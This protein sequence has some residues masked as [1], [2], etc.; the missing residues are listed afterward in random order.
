[1][2]ASLLAV[3]LIACVLAVIP[4]LLCSRRVKGA[5]V[6]G[7]SNSLVISASCHVVPLSAVDPFAA[8]E[9]ES[10]SEGTPLL[11][12]PTDTTMMLQERSAS[13]NPGADAFEMQHLLESSSTPRAVSPQPGGDIKSEEEKQT[14]TRISRSL[15]RWGA[16]KTPNSPQS[17]PAGHEGVP[18]H[19]G[20]GTM[21]HDIQIPI[22]G[23]WYA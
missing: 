2:T 23:H 22:D 8:R 19:L 9:T 6:L 11:S 13:I 18:G 5:M 3:F 20:F 21:E 17:Q 7:G 10:G 4:F 16:I 15:I 1:M 14:L 12:A